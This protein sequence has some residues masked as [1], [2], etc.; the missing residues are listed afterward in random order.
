MEWLQIREHYERAFRHAGGNQTTVAKAGGL[1]KPNLVG[2]FL[3]NKKKTKGPAVE[4]F[5]RAVL[6]LGLPPSEFFRT[7]EQHVQ[8]APEDAINVK[9]AR[10]RAS[11][12]VGPAL[13]RVAI[14]HAAQMAIAAF[15]DALDNSPRPRPP[16]PRKHR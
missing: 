1:K 13:D 15:F 2:K 7:L 14:Q 16:T 5:I 8:G 10:A 11:R 12:L 6:G 3:N 4:T 9:A